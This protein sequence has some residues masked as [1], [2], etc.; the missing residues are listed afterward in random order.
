MSDSTSK[1][2]LHDTTHIQVKGRPSVLPWRQESEFTHPPNDKLAFV[3]GKGDCAPFVDS[4]GAYRYPIRCAECNT[5]YCRWKRAKVW[6]AAI[7]N[8]FRRKRQQVTFVTFTE[9]DRPEPV[10]ITS[11]GVVLPPTHSASERCKSQI[12]RF[13]RLSRTAIF[14]NTFSG[15]LWVAECTQRTEP[16]DLQER[17]SDDSVNFSEEWKIHPHIHCVTLGSRIDIPALTRIAER[18]GFSNVDVREIRPKTRVGSD[19]KTRPESWEEA[20]HRSVNYISNYLRKEQPVL[21][22]RD[23]WGTLRKESSAVRQELE[24]KRKEL[25]LSYTNQN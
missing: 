14:R 15:G 23:T 12:Q 1:P 20:V 25:L 24:D 5:M 3:C 8:L 10:I 19:G 7:L 4:M 2:N 21:R 18:Y 17:L 9:R 6:R 16:V 22:S 11:G 13:R